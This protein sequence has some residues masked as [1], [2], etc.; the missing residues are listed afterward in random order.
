M[1]NLSLFD[2]DPVSG[3]TTYWEDTD[4]GFKLHTTQDCEAII[5][6]NKARQRTPGWYRLDN[7]MWRVASIPIGIQ[8]EWLVKY[9]IRDI[10]SDEY[11]PKVRR[12]LNDPD[13]RYLK[14]GEIII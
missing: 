4:T 9:G 2:H 1:S 5:E 12:L 11:W 13:Y 14:C 6:A 8:Y 7:D 3:L 10:T